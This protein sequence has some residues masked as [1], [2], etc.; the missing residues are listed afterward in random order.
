MF[1][2]DI[3]ELLHFLHSFTAWG[4]GFYLLTQF[5]TGKFHT[6]FGSKRTL[7]L[8]ACM[9]FHGLNLL[10]SLYI[11]SGSFSANL[12][13]Y[14]FSSNFIAHIILAGIAIS[15]FGNHLLRILIYCSTFILLTA[16]AYIFTGNLFLCSLIFL[17]IPA[18]ILYAAA[19]QHLA[20]E[21]TDKKERSIFFRL[22]LFHVLYM[23]IQLPVNM[24]YLPL[25]QTNPSALSLLPMF[26]LLSFLILNLLFVNYYSLTHPRIL[27]EKRKKH[28]KSQIALPALAMMRS[29][30]APA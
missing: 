13:L 10:L 19:M 14:S 9:I 11:H 2:P 6:A 22:G 15:L 4:F 27:P 29:I 30:V 8:S 7:A 17:I 23:L 20:M 18:D 5:I 25:I 3:C 24:R 26:C 16:G 21:S 1:T 12:E 28:I